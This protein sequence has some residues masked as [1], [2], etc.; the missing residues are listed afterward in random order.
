MIDR[1]K[2]RAFRLLRWTEKY[3]KTDM[4]YLASGGFWLTL[5][6]ILL[7]FIALGVSIAFANLLPKHIFGEYKFVFS[8]LAI[9]SLTTLPGLGTSVVRSVAK[10]FDGT[11]F[12]ILKTKILWGLAGSLA[13]T[14]IA[15]YYYTQGNL[16]L[17]GAFGVVAL[18][19]PFIDTFNIYSTI[20]TGKKL[21]RA[22]IVYETIVQGFAALVIVGTLYVTDSLV[23]VFFSYFASY[24]FIRLLT[25][26]YILRRYTTN[27][28]VDS[29]ALP[30][31]LH[32]SVMEVLGTVAESVNTILLW[33]FIGPAELAVYAFAKALPAQIN[34]GLRKLATIALP[35]FAERDIVNI[36]KTLLRRLLWL[37]VGLFLMFLVYVLSAPLI[38]ETL[39]PQY[40]DSIFYSQLAALSILFF[41]KKIIG[42]VFNAHAKKGA[43]Y[44]N[45]LMTPL[46]QLAL[47]VAL[48]PTFGILGAISVGLVAQLFSL[49]LVSVLLVYTRA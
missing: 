30:H 12:A 39:F 26:W 31:G 38:F 45:A 16:G 44:M 10:G 22:S 34:T 49:I 6:T 2:N 25:L 42:T 13:S 11:P 35:K 1:Y 19:L 27:H 32:L 18:F 5:K 4:A 33:L 15:F 40:T 9:L 43:L 7:A 36:K 3:T 46:V 24:T 47:S 20:L 21:F 17:A 41:P 29:E 28:A 23:F 14:G 48:V 8:I 37:W